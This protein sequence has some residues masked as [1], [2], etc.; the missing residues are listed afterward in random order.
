M[1]HPFV[2]ARC[3][4]A[5]PASTPDARSLSDGIRMV[6]SAPLTSAVMATVIVDR[7]VATS[8]TLLPDLAFESSLGTATA[9]SRF[10]SIERIW[11]KKCPHQ[12]AGSSRS[13]ATRASRRRWQDISSSIRVHRG[14]PRRRV[15]SPATALPVGHEGVIFGGGLDRVLGGIDRDWTFS[16][17]QSNRRGRGFRGTGKLA[18]VREEDRGG[19]LVRAGRRMGRGRGGRIA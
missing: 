5:S 4:P 11:R 18:C 17:P 2:L 3:R 10:P 15:R 6:P 9:S 13:H 19:R 14:L 12:R 1:G 8:A 16:V 7:A